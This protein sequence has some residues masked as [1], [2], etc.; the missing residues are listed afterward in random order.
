MNRK[1]IYAAKLILVFSIATNISCSR[2]EIIKEERVSPF[3]FII[4]LYDRDIE[5]PENDRRSY[6]EIYIDK[7]ESCRTTIGLES[8]KKIFETN[9]TPDRHLV[10]IEKWIL[11]DSQ[12]RYIKLNNLYQP[13]PDFIYVNIEEGKVIRVN[14]E[15]TKYGASLY[16]LTKE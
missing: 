5:N 16:T 1:A 14:V 7:A 12:G 15:S 3:N 8:Q 6:Y 9:L 10:K 11:D 2:K 13:K 4:T